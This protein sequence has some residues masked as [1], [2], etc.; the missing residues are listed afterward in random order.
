MTDIDVY[1]A[2]GFWLNFP[3]E[4]IKAVDVTDT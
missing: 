1:L 4:A 2:P 3:R